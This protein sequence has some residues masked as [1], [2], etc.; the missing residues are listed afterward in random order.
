MGHSGRE[1]RVNSTARGTSRSPHLILRLPPGYGLLP[2]VLARLRELPSPPDCAH[3]PRL[4]VLVHGPPA[5][6]AERPCTPRTRRRPP[7]CP[8]ARY[9]ESWRTKI[10]YGGRDQL[11]ALFAESG[12]IQ[13]VLAGIRASDPAAADAI[14]IAQSA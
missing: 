14:A 4:P 9:Q 5:P 2:E 8:H 6:T 10:I 3:E 11:T 12:Q 1:R 7:G 13:A